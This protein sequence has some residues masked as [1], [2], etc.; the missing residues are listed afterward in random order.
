M[1]HLTIPNSDTVP[2]IPRQEMVSQIPHVKIEYFNKTGTTVYIKDRQ[3]ASQMLPSLP[4]EA[5]LDGKFHVVYSWHT[6]LYANLSFDERPTDFFKTNT[7]LVCKRALLS[8]TLD[9]ELITGTDCIFSRELGLLISLDRPLTPVD[10]FPDTSKG[11]M[12]NV[13]YNDV[14]LDKVN[15]IHV[16][17][18]VIDNA[19]PGSPY[20]INIED[21]IYKITS[22][23]SGD[24]SNLPDGV[25]VLESRGPVEGNSGVRY[26]LK[27]C[28]YSVGDKHQCPI[29]LFTNPHDAKTNGRRTALMEAKFH[30]KELEL[31]EQERELISLKN[32]LAKAKEEALIRK[33]TIDQRSDTRKD[34]Y[35]DRSYSRKD[36]SESIS[37]SGKTIA[38]VCSVAVAAFGLFKLLI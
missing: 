21:R 19:N 38:G 17:I 6:T 16:N 8:Y 10:V 5:A 35:E 36:H 31:K 7:P 3:G 15:S 11:I 22:V 14:T 28:I 32:L 27:D 29:T 20:Y 33:E 18:V 25:H 1:L 4:A 23:I 13:Q 12:Q 30:E 24:G 34:Y 26:D 37:I 9:P 2:N